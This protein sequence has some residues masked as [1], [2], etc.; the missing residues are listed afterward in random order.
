MVVATH[1]LGY[2][3]PAGDPRA[4]ISFTVR[5][6]AVPVFFMCDGFLLA[7]QLAFQ[8][9]DFC[10]TVLRS[11]ER[12]LLPWLVFSSLYTAA[13]FVFELLAIV[14][15]VLVAGQSFWT[16]I[17]NVYASVIAPQM[18]FLLSLFIIRLLTPLAGKLPRSPAITAAVFVIYAGAYRMSEPAL[19]GLFSYGLDPILHALWGL[20]FYLLGIL[21]NNLKRWFVWGVFF[22]PILVT[23]AFAA[24]FHIPRSLVSDAL[25]QY[26]YLLGSFALFAGLGKR[27]WFLPS[28]GRE[29]MGIY[30]IHAPVLL[31]FLAVATGPLPLSPPAKLGLITC[32]VFLISLIISKGLRHLPHG[33]VLLGELGK[34]TRAGATSKEPKGRA[35]SFHSRGGSAPF[36]T[37][38]TP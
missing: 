5:T 31:K 22:G 18:Y 29:T 15:P 27:S 8:K 26:G 7:H 13:R 38:K 28:I 36:G 30:L 9:V 37:R 20:Q 24:R 4:V 32:A 21:V 19:A 25:V 33:P 23:S 14:P 6:I 34:K 11:A 3:E 12:L 1:S 2:V 16:V 10:R 17:A 35:T